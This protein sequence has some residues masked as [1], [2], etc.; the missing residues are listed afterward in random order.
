MTVPWPSRPL[1][2]QD[3]V[4]VQAERVLGPRTAKRLATFGDGGAP[5]GSQVRISVDVGAT[6]RLRAAGLT[7]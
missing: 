2:R 1:P 7:R 6:G 4:K 5:G 3:S